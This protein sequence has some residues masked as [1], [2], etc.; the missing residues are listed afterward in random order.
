MNKK[1]SK[2]EYWFKEQG[3]VKHFTEA[4]NDI[5]DL[6]WKNTDKRHRN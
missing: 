4:T 3:P 6:K 1:V 2:T 5:A